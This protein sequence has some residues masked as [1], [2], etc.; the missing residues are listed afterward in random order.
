MCGVTV[1]IIVVLQSKSDTFPHVWCHSSLTGPEM[2]G[3]NQNSSLAES[4]FTKNVIARGVPPPP[5]F[6]MLQRTMQTETANMDMPSKG[7]MICRCEITK[8]Q[9]SFV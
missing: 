8:R 1:K 2:K 7:E 3:Y 5:P 4:I 9:K 6:H